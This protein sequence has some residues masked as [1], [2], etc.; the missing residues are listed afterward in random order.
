MWLVQVRGSL[1]KP[2]DHLA[3]SEGPRG[4]WAGVREGG[5]AVGVDNDNPAAFKDGVARPLLEIGLHV[6]II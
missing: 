1:T 3:Q 5:L 4:C 6:I 2:A